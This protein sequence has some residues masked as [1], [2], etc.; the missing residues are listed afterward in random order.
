MVW[1][2]F[3][4]LTNVFYSFV[5]VIDQVLRRNHIK[6]DVSL[7]ILW[8]VS[9]FFIWV[10]IVPFIDVTVPELPKL[11]AALAAGFI[12]VLVALPYY[13]S[14]SVEEVSKVMPIW[15]FASL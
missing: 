15:Q 2:V 4:L 7:T 5:N 10:A 3:A 12:A 14:L 13:Y 9:F 8:V 6:H 1:L 11:I